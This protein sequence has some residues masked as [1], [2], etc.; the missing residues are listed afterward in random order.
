MNTTTSEKELVGK[1]VL[2][3]RLFP[4]EADRPTTRWLDMQCRAGK[5]PF[6]RLGRLIYFD[7]A[8]VHAAITA[9]AI[10]PRAHHRSPVTA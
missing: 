2:L 4:N 3:E 7:V 9:R 5:I 8:Q 1:K 10:G 6:I